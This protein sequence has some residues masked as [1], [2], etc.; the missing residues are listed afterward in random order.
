MAPKKA[1]KKNTKADFDDDAD[2]DIRLGDIP[3]AVDSSANSKAPAAKKKKAKKKP[4][5]GDWS[6]DDAVDAPAEPQLQEGDDEPPSRGR[7]AKT[8]PTFAALQARTGPLCGSH[9]CRK[10][11]ERIS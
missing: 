8:I 1:K 2:V 5:A 10:S 6:E 11:V 3:V 4:T 7:A 9:V